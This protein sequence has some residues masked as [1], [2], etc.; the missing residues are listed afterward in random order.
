MTDSFVPLTRLILRWAEAAPDALAIVEHTGAAVSY[1]SLVTQI[2]RLATALRKHG[3]S[4]GMRIGLWFPEGHWIAHSTGYF[5]AMLANGVAVV[6][7]GDASRRTLRQ[8]ADDVGLGMVLSDAESDTSWTD[9]P[10]LHATDSSASSFANPQVHAENLPEFADVIFTS[11]STGRPKGVAASHRVL[12]SMAAQY[13][14]RP[15]GARVIGHALS[16]TT[17]V[18]RQI[19]LAAVARGSTMVTGAPFHARNFLQLTNA[20]GI[21]TAVLPAA[22]GRALR[23][24]LESDPELTPVDLRNL[25]FVSDSLNPEEHRRLAALLP[26]T[27]VIN[28]YG[29]TE[30]GD[31]HLVVTVDDCDLGPGGRP[32]PGTEVRIVRRTGEWADTGETG[33]ICIRDANPLLTYMTESYRAQYIWRD[34]WTRTGD[35][36]S[37]DANGRVHIRGRMESHARVGGHTVD[38]STVQ[39][40]LE[41]HPQVDEAAVISIPHPTLG[42]SIAALVTPAIDSNPA[43]MRRFLLDMIPEYAIPAPLV[44]V[45]EIPRSRNGKPLYEV[46]ER[47]ISQHRAATVEPCRTDLEMTIS[48]VWSEKLDIGRLPGRNENFHDLGGDSLAAVQILTEL[49]E[50]L[51][52]EIPPEALTTT[53]NLGEFAASVEQLRTPS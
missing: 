19:L 37:I 32:A 20:Y 22:A 43:E 7:P 8:I 33:I 44:A 35:L 24:T 21:E 36:G 53:A 50:R 17:A 40:A 4:D 9:L 45:D 13:L 15:G 23:L 3:A 39:L 47:I 26:H 31:A 11:G 41:E 30:G 5:A 52:H 12:A 34:G 29:L 16:H 10:T 25:R 1:G 49:E 18:G 42:Q 2:E 27:R 38:L 48:A 14:E 51:N 6:L 46:I 28:T